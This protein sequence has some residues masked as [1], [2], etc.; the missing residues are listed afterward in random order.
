MRASTDLAPSSPAR[1][2]TMWRA[3]TLI[4]VVDDVSYTTSRIPV[5]GLAD[6]VRTGGEKYSIPP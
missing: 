5:S 6:L 3:S 2:T 4:G 1:G